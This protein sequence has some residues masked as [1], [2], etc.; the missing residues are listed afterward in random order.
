MNK[1]HFV[2]DIFINQKDIT[3]KK[4]FIYEWQYIFYEAHKKTVKKQ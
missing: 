2:G 3:N 1:Q 4:L